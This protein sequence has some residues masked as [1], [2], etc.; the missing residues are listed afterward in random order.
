ML[1]VVRGAL[2]A[3]AVLGL[4]AAPLGSVAAASPMASD[5]PGVVEMS[6]D[7]DMAA[8]MAMPCCPDE[9]PVPDC[10]KHCPMI[11]CGA[12]VA[13]TL[14]IATDFAAPH[15]RAAQLVE[16]AD[17]AFTGTKPIPPP[18]PPKA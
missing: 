13:P 6:S 9:A 10:G 7:T 11:A 3:L 5:A 16:T 12:P 8:N 2:A 4:V 14:P 1:T 18:R 17:E 15:D